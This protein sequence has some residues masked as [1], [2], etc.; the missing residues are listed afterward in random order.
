VEGSIAALDALPEV[1][2]AVKKRVPV[3]FDSGIRRGPDILKAV[4]LGATA[5]LIGRPFA[6]ALASDGELGVRH[7]IRTLMADVDLTLA[8]S[9]RTSVEELD[10][11]F[12]EKD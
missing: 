2:D 12:L 4:A 5:V 10:K 1:C 11:S 9:G 6:Y 7:L 8:L 3:L